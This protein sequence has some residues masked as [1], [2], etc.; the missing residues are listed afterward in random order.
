MGRWI[1]NLCLFLFLFIFSASFSSKSEKGNSEITPFVYPDLPFFPKI[2]H[3][4]NEPSIEGAELGRY[5]FYDPILSSDSTFSCSSCH[6]QEAAFS[7]APKAFSKGINNELMVRNTMPLFNLLWYPSLFW[8]G[9]AKSIETQIF[10]PVRAHNEMNLNWS[11]AENRIN[12]SP[13]YKKKFSEIF[14]LSWVDSLTIAKAIGQFERTLLSYNSKYDRVLN[15]ELFFTADEFKG[16]VLVN[17][18]TKGDCLHC[19]TTDGNALATTG[20]FS[21]N[22]LDSIFAAE[23]YKDKGRANFTKKESDIAKFKI[24]SLRNLSFTS[25]YMHDGRFSS[26]EEVLDFY[27]TGVHMSYNVDSKMN[28]AREGGVHLTAEEK[29]MIISFLITLNDSVFVSNPAFAS[30][31][32]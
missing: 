11:E 32:K 6:R 27:S 22:G 7:D 5:L 20:E 17:D 19:H 8:D 15:G 24:P 9:R 16:F 18:Q 23:N 10:V 3:C 29:R 30:P 4:N 26:L 25:P 13:F 12:K 14:G 2:P 31:F 28:H 1:L 21:N